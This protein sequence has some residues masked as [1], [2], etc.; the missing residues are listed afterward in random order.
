[1]NIEPPYDNTHYNRMLEIQAA[2]LRRALSPNR[3]PRPSEA[4]IV[5]AKTMLLVANELCWQE[6][7]ARRG[8]RPDA[9]R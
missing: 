3:R 2:A 7:C 5:S 6:W 1:M 8:Q 9:G 4:V